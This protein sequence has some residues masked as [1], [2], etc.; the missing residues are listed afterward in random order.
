M[1][2]PTKWL[3][4]LALAL[5]IMWSAASADPVDVRCK[6]DG[7]VALCT[8]PTVVADPATAPVDAD[9]WTYSLCDFAGTYTWREA[10]WAT[11][12]N[13]KPLFDPEVVPVSSAFERIVHNAC[14]MGVTDSGWG[15]TIPSNILCWTGGTL[16]KNKTSYREFRRLDFNGL[17]PSATGC[18]A[19]WT[20]TVF[21]QRGRK[22]VCPETYA[23]RLK[24][25]GDLECWKLPPECPKPVSVVGN[26]ITLLDG[27][28]VQRELDYRSRTPGGVEVERFY[29]SGGYFRFDAAPKRS[30]DLW[31][32]TWDRRIVVPPTGG[33]VLA[34]AQRADGSVLAFGSSGREMQNNQGGGSALL[35][36]LADAAGATSGWRLTTAEMDVETYD[37]SGRLTA[38][39]LRT[40]KGYALSYANGRLA[41]VTDTFG[42]VVTFTYDESGRLSGFVA[43][44]NRVH[45][46]GYDAIG[47]LAS[48]T[49]PDNAV[50]SY[51]YEDTNFVHALTGI[52]DENGARYARWAYD[53]AGRA[54]LSQHAG[55]VESV[56]LYYGAYSPSANDGQTSVVDGFGT[57]H[58]YY[59]QVAGAVVRIRFL[60]DAAGTR[61]Y[62]F[63]ANGNIA[64]FRDANGVQTNYA[65]DLTRNLE[66]SRTEAYGTTVARTIATEWHPLF[67]LPTRITAPSSVAGVNETTDLTYDAQG[68]LLQKTVSGGGKSRQWTMTYSQLGQL[69]TVD[70]PRTDVQDVV[71]HTYYDATDSC[72]GC[73]GN[74][75]TTTN[76]L[77]HVTTFEGYDVDGQPTR[78]VDPNG[79]VTTMA[80]DNRGRLRTRT[81]H[82]GSP[83]A[84]TTGFDYDAAGQLVKVTMPDGST[85]SYQYDAAHRLTEI[86]DSLGNVTQY[87]LDAMGNRI[88]AKA[89]A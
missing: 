50:R 57:T 34:Y 71:S 55:G 41:T 42:A 76:A 81:V 53:G 11:A 21:A 6:A 70:G 12:Q 89:I 43:P 66:I 60:S 31:R 85:L 5:S 52:T 20:E 15:Y 35:L 27:C 68:N 48:V 84:E 30:S 45:A 25:S 47:R 40:G 33:F 8:E 17:S 26:P 58:T 36:R 24:A 28:K 61:N 87:T 77:G 74:V 73:R 62:S 1:T 63:D 80:Y 67:R 39:A 16:V 23:T 4:L 46:Y 29:N 82:A 59:Y 7:G 2:M 72:A 56:A 10:A 86:S 49:Y 54:T 22:L 79:V 37:A 9:D 38:I 64:T 88:D 51:H 78:V 19:S 18:N 65:Y 83:L 69:L 13:G 14:Q 3:F 75:K 32:T 44:G